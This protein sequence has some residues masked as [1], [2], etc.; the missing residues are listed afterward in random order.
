[1]PRF[2]DTRFP[3]VMDLFKPRHTDPG[4]NNLE[5]IVKMGFGD[6][7]QQSNNNSCKRRFTAKFSNEKRDPVGKRERITSHS[8]FKSCVDHIE[9]SLHFIF[10]TEK[11]QLCLIVLHA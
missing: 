6:V 2:S 8:L 9:T 7:L 1:M 3:R 11:S 5:S 10:E 4:K